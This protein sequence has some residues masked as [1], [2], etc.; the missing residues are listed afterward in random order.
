P[1]IPGVYLLDQRCGAPSSTGI[2]GAMSGAHI[3]VLVSGVGFLYDEI[4]HLLNIR[5]TGN[6]ETFLK[7]EYLID[8]DAGSALKGEPLE[9][10]GKR[11]FEFI[12]D[13]ASGRA[14]P[15]D[16]A[17]KE[18]ALLIPY[19]GDPGFKEEQIFISTAKDAHRKKVEEIM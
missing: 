6:P 14:V 12:L 7:P 15:K 18:K 4:P 5:E 8:F 19:E 13:V 1:G 3:N 10:T 11:L 2:Y 16:E 17:K 9:E